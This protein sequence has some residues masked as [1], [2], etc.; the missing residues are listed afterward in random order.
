MCVE[1]RGDLRSVPVLVRRILKER[2]D[3]YWE[4]LIVDP[5]DPL[6]LR[7]LHNITGTAEKQKNWLN[8]LGVACNRGNVGAVLLVLDG[9]SKQFEGQPF[10]P[11]SA[12][13]ALAERAKSV[14]A[15]EAFSL[16]CVFAC[17]EFESWLIAGIESL[18]G[19]KI[20][21][22]AGVKPATFAPEFD[23]EAR[24]AAKEWLSDQMVNGY[25]PATDQLPLAEMV[26]LNLIRNRRLN[27]F[28]RLEHAVVELVEAMRTGRH[29]SSPARHG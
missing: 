14:R 15:G 24:R 16:A 3:G 19:K 18:A 11:V 4:H 29:I 21:D 10:C 25:N 7:G 27:S 12:A 9:D 20:G 8:K 26:D 1:G 23:I 13:C 22:R 17:K 2:H 28:E 6:V 5:I